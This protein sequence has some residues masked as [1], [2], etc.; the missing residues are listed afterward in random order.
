[1]TWGWAEPQGRRHKF[2]ANQWRIVQ[3]SGALYQGGARWGRRRGGDGGTVFCLFME[4]S[5]TSPDTPP[6]LYPEGFQGNFIPVDAAAVVRLC[7][8]RLTLSFEKTTSH[9]TEQSKQANRGHYGDRRYPGISRSSSE[10]WHTSNS[11][12]TCCSAEGSVLMWASAMGRMGSSHQGWNHS[13][14]TPLAACTRHTLA[15]RFGFARQRGPGWKLVDAVGMNVL[16]NQRRLKRDELRRKARR[17][18]VERRGL[19]RSRLVNSS[20]SRGGRWH[21]D[22][23][24]D[25]GIVRMQLCERVVK[26]ATRLDATFGIRDFTAGGCRLVD[27][28]FHYVELVDDCLV[29]RP[30]LVRWGGIEI[31]YCPWPFTGARRVGWTSTFIRRVWLLVGG[32]GQFIVRAARERAARMRH[33]GSGRARWGRRRGGDSGTVFAAKEASEGEALGGGWR[34]SAPANGDWVAV[35]TPLSLFVEPPTDSMLS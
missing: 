21:V 33:I 9:S 8:D 14:T 24:W 22:G 5:F 23:F 1:M 19:H 3:I 35:G 34:E 10:S 4:Q 12:S 32:C 26:E 15:L 30:A 16:W 27:H 20:R 31:R 6:N 29:L 18:A 13:W 11:K 28:R 7:V 17:R 25:R 2:A